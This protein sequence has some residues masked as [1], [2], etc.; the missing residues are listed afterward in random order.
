MQLY[1]IRRRN[2]W[3]SPEEVE[4]IGKRAKEVADSDSPVRS[5]GSAV[6]SW[7]TRTAR[8]AAS[9]STRRS[10]P[11]PFAGTPSVSACPPTRSTRSSRRSWCARTPRPH[12]PRHEPDGAA[13]GP[14]MARRPGLAPHRERNRMTTFKHCMR[15]ELAHRISDGIEVTLFW[16]E[17]ADAVGLEV[18]DRRTDEMLAVD[19]ER[20][21]ALEA[22]NH[23]FAYAAMRWG[24]D[25]AKQTHWRRARPLP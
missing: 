14:A 18:L 6:T 19:V 1:T 9:A 13:G 25:L 3:G 11:R 8:S 21:A 15:R 22:F 23:P 2:A 20:H 7:P 16:L 5:A 4:A 10:T 12:R 17:G 24:S